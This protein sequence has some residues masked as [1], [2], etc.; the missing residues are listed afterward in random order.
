MKLR[1]Y[2]GLVSRGPWVSIAKVS[3]EYICHVLSTTV[4][5]L[6]C[7]LCYVRFYLQATK[8]WVRELAGCQAR[9]YFLMLD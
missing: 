8:A 4:C 3:C 5:K 1:L 7:V 6:A 9:C 2:P